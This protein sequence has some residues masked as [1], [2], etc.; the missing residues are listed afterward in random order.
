MECPVCVGSGIVVVNTGIAEVTRLLNEARAEN[1][2]HRFLRFQ[3]TPCLICM[4][5]HTNNTFSW[6]QKMLQYSWQDMFNC[7]II[8]CHNIFG[9]PVVI[10]R[11]MP[12]TTYFFLIYRGFII[13]AKMVWRIRGLA[14]IL[15]EWLHCNLDESLHNMMNDLLC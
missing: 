10:I 9:Q 5:R 12:D 3:S 6:R 8:F 13:H 4:V 11:W 2:Y 7:R 15:S 14:F 1:P